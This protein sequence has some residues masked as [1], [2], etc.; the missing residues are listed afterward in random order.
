MLVAV[1]SSTA[2][3]PPLRV[4]RMPP[5]A[6]Q[7]PDGSFAPA[8]LVHAPQ[9]R[10]FTGILLVPGSGLQRSVFTQLVQVSLL[11]LAV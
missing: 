6:L 7:Q 11:A 3:Q 1:A 8:S 10:G 4:D 5:I 2:T 9:A